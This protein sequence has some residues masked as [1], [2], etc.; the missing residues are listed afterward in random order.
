M[1]VV[2]MERMAL[3]DLDRALAA[4]WRVWNGTGAYAAGSSLGAITRREHGLLVA[5]GP[6]GARRVLVSKVDEE[7]ELRE[8]GDEGGERFA[9]STNE[10]HDGTIQPNG[11]VWMEEMRIDGSLPVWR[12]RARDVEPEKT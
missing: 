1:D 7:L 6:D 10:Y 5:S 4:E 11:Y 3:L 8:A 12:W 2:V 9:L